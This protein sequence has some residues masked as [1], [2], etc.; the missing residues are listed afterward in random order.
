MAR[1]IRLLV[2]AP[3]ATAALALGGCVVTPDVVEPDVPCGAVSVAPLAQ[4]SQAP[5]VDI[6]QVVVSQ[7]QALPDF[8]STRY[9][10]TD[11]AALDD[12]EA[13]L[14]DRI[15]PGGITETS[16]CAGQRTTVLEVQSTNAGD[17]TVTVDTCAE[18]PIADEI[19][20]LAS[21]WLATGALP[22][23]P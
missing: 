19:D 13:I 5:P 15:P 18:A 16:D 23:A 22:P 6:V 4:C 1:S 9:L 17:F 2:T 21:A 12:L 14:G 20:D 8:D 3:L 7:S 11:P 10:Q